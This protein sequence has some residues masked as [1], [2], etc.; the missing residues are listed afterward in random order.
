MQITDSHSNYYIPS[1]FLVIIYYLYALNMQ[2]SRDK[3]PYRE[4]TI[5]FVI[6]KGKIICKIGGGGKYIKFPGGGVDNGETPEK[7]VKRELLEEL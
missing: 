6:Y 2:K 1:D 3:L 5:C 7:A 4:T